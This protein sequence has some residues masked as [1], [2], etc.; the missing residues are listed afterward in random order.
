MIPFEQN[1]YVLDIL[2]CSL[3][4]EN[5]PS[6]SMTK[7]LVIEIFMRSVNKNKNGSPVDPV[8]RKNTSR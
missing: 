6:K 2:P 4:L 3:F 5:Y 1:D 8:Y 7:Q